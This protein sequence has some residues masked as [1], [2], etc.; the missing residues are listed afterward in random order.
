MTFR[1]LIELA[2]WL[3]LASTAFISGWAGPPHPQLIN[4]PSVQA[5]AASR[6]AS[7]PEHMSIRPPRYGEGCDCPYDRAE[8]GSACEGSSA[9]WRQG[10]LQPACYTDD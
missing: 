10:G 6:A 2:V 3:C 4:S 5:Y 9:Y 7:A 8:D 1:R